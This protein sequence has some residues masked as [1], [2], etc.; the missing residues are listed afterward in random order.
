MQVRCRCCQSELG[1]RYVQAD[2]EE[3]RYKVGCVLVQ[4]MR[5]R[6]VQRAPKE[7][8]GPAETWGRPAGSVPLP[9]P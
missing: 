7:A 5:L 9:P 6:R 8:Q 3:Q 4:Q 1:W 2:T